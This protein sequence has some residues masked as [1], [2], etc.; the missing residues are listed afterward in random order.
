MVRPL[1]TPCSVIPSWYE[2]RT[3][4]TPLSNPVLTDD[5][6]GRQEQE[7]RRLAGVL[8]SPSTPTCSSL[9]RPS[10]SLCKL[11]ANPSSDPSRSYQDCLSDISA[12]ALAVR[13][14]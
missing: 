2:G 8:P 12:S 10:R 4:T 1:R 6:V 3:D 11:Q 13:P 7:G 9:D 14:R 5:R